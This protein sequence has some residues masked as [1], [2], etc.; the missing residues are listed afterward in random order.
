MTNKTQP[1]GK[2]TIKPIPVHERIPKKW[3]EAK[4]KYSHTQQHR[5]NLLAE[6]S[7]MQL[8]KQATQLLK[9]EHKTAFNRDYRGCNATDAFAMQVFICPSFYLYL[10]CSYDFVYRVKYAFNSCRHEGEI[11]K[12]LNGYLL[13][14][15]AKEVQLK[16]DFNTFYKNV[17]AVQDPKHIISL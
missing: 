17:L 3:V 10:E 8:L 1:K 7:F 13:K 5:D 15:R 2:G 9:G 16:P 6:H 14:G 4:R 12:L 11:R